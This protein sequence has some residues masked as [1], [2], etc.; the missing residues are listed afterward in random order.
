MGDVAVKITALH[1]KVADAVASILTEARARSLNVGV[2]SGVR[3]P[4]DQEKLYALGRTVVNPNGKTPE[5]PLGD[6]V[7]NGKPWSSWHNYGL[8]IDI[9]FKNEK[10]W[11]W[12]KKF[13]E[14][15]E[16]GKVGE[17]FNLEW[18]GRWKMQDLPHFQKRGSIQGVGHAKEILFS[19]GL[20]FLWNLV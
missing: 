6:I 16:L 11:T 9:V 18:G 4:E 7:T 1:P 15:E 20:D 13:D 14:W 19:K 2:F 17:I 3:Q 10:G 5:K 8:A 12:D